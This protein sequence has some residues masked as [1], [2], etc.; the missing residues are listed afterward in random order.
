MLIISTLREILRGGLM[1][2]KE[3]AY[4]RLSQLVEKFEANQSDYRD[5]NYNETLTRL[6]FIN[7]FFEILNWDINNTNMVAQIRRDIV[8][9]D[10]VI[11]S[12][13]KKSIRNR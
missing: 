8:H 9:E 7:P 13:N 12:E 3:S 11:V 2:T 1:Y 6:D 5:S 10:K 4:Q